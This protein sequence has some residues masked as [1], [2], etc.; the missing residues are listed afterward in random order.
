MDTNMN[1]TKWYEIG[2]MFWDIEC[3]EDILIEWD[4]KFVG[5][6]YVENYEWTWSHF[7]PDMVDHKQIEW[8]KIRLTPQNKKRV[9]DVLRAV[10][11][12]GKVTENE[13]VVYGYR[14]DAEYI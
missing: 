4:V 9:V 5:Y 14:T 6:D 1:N 3:S 8:L 10:H 11:V 12:P 2:H 13:A 7:G